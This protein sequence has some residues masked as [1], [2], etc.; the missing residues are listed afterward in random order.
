MSKTE[1]K[2]R[3]ILL[4][5]DGTYECSDA[6]LDYEKI[7]KI[8]DGGCMTYVP[9][10][11]ID[12]TATEKKKRPLHRLEL[13]ADD[14]GMMKDLTSNPWLAVVCSLGFKAS[15]LGLAGPLIL[16]PHNERGFLPADAPNFIAAAKTLDNGDNAM[17]FEDLLVYVEQHGRMCPPDPVKKKR[18]RPESDISPNK[19]AKIVDKA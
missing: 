19:R 3:Y 4:K 16:A 10:K 1:K 2:I 17:A 12:V 11:H 14:G 18:A 8:L 15:F 7:E 13:I 6:K 9:N 5:T